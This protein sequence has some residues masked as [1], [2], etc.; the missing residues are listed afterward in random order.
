[1]AL[2]IS[3]GSFQID[4]RYRCAIAKSTRLGR[5]LSHEL[6]IRV[7]ERGGNVSPPTRRSMSR[8]L[9]GP[10]NPGM[11]EYVSR[12][13]LRGWRRHCVSFCNRLKIGLP[14]FGANDCQ[15]LTAW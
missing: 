13:G 3:S 4:A 14:A 6:E 5:N 1:M 11:P 9:L 10:G 2:R 12:L 7:R 8:R 15:F